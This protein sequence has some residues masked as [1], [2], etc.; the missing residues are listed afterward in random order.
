MA[1]VNIVE[2][3]DQPKI[4]SSL[5]SVPIW[6]EAMKDAFSTVNNTNACLEVCQNFAPS[7]IEIFPSKII[8]KSKRD[9]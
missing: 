9:G 5:K 7:N 8:L 4:D 1:Q 6:I 3:V 2:G